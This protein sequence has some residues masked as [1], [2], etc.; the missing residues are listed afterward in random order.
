MAE[1]LKTAILR[2]WT[3][4]NGGEI[5]TTTAEAG[6]KRAQNY[7]EWCKQPKVLGGKFRIKDLSKKCWLKD[8][9]QWLW[10]GKKTEAPKPIGIKATNAKLLGLS[11]LEIGLRATRKTIILMS[12]LLGDRFFRPPNLQQLHFINPHSNR[13]SDLD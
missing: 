7:R 4:S 1:D 12:L 6:F 3:V 8:Q 11:H 13:N 5:P 10:P 2:R 9:D